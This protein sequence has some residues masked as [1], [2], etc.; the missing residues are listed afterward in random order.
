MLFLKKSPKKIAKGSVI[1]LPRYLL[2][3]STETFGVRGKVV[4]TNDVSTELTKKSEILLTD[5]NSF[6]NFNVEITDKKRK[7]CRNSGKSSKKITL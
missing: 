5:R 3:D 6:K 1:K 7:K 2:G 4:R